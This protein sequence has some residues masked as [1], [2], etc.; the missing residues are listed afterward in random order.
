[1]GEAFYAPSG[2]LATRRRRVVACSSQSHSA[3][4]NSPEKQV[5]SSGLRVFFG[6]DLLGNTRIDQFLLG[7]FHQL[8]NEK[9]VGRRRA[10]TF[11]CKRGRRQWLA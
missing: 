4:E 5:A 6:R 8:G 10:G 11:G 1:M 7:G 3:N 9:I 2:N